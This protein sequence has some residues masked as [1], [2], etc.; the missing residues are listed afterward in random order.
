MHHVRRW[1][2]DHT[3]ELQSAWFNGI[4]VMVWEVVFGVWV[5]WSDRDAQVLRRMVRAQRALSHLLRRR[6]VD[7]AG[8]PRRGRSGAGVF[9]S[10]FAADGRAAHGAR[11]PQRR[12]RGG[13]ARRRPATARHTTSGPAA[14][15]RRTAGT[16]EVV[17][18]ARG[19]GGL[20]EAPTAAGRVL[21]RPDPPDRGVGGVPRTV[22][23]VA[24][25][26]PTVAPSR[27]TARTSSSRPGEHVLTVRYRCR[28]TGMYDGAP[29][30]DEWKPLPP[31]LHDLRTLERGRHARPGP[32]G[33]RGPRGDEREFAEFV[34]ATGHR[35][36]VPGGRVPGMAGSLDRRTPTRSDRSPRWTSPTRAAYAAW[37]GARLP[38][39]DEWQLA[40][41]R[42]RVRRARARR[43]GTYRERAQRRENAV[44]DAEGWRGPPQ[45]GSSWYFDGGPR[46]PDFSAKY[47]VPGLGSRPL[48][49]HRLPGR[50]AARRRA[51]TDDRA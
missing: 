48:D 45:R 37:A 9:G 32:V 21:A 34:A 1:H 28:E 35:P 16:V 29:F 5:G 8:R 36:A 12:R 2:R 27:P 38:T 18:P 31:R 22:A 43:C 20:W 4:G 25:P 10:T 17:V 50:L 42:A 41:G 49:E 24:S 39:E 44:H 30:V 47:L 33:G 40:A 11:Q 3:E 7:A 15:W 13:A 6:R 46:E 14:R 19:I 26:R 51:V 23:P